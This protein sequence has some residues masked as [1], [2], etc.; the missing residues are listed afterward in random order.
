MVNFPMLTITHVGTPSTPLSLAQ[1]WI[2]TPEPGFQQANA[3][4]N[5]SDSTLHIH[6]SLDDLH[7]FS[8]ATESN[9]SL[10]LLG[11]TVE[12]FLMLPDAP[13]YHE[14]HVSPQNHRTAL[15]WPLGGIEKVRYQGVPLEDFRENPDS[16]DTRVHQLEHGWEADFD[17]PASILGLEAYTIGQALFVSVSRY[18]YTDLERP[19]V[20]ST[21]AAHSVKNFHRP[22]DWL[23]AEL[24]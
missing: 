23:P 12:V 7:I 6:I 4:L 13:Q 17:I 15:R 24:A 11:D 20:L 21:I 1:P 8:E 16:F 14:F 9:Q 2:D 19:P 10:H 3:R 5:W 22:E 18:D